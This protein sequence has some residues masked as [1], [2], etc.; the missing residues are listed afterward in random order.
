MGVLAA[1]T[2]ELGATAIGAEGFGATHG[3]DIMLADDPASFAE[4]ITQLYGNDELW[5]GLATDSRRLIEK[6]FAPEVIAETINRS[7]RSA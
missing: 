1:G 3:V 4:A 5:Q 7:I 2:V 6:H